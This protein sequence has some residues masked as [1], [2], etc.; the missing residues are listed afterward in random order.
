MVPLKTGHK[1]KKWPNEVKMSKILINGDDNKRLSPQGNRT[2][3]VIHMTTL[4]SVVMWTTDSVLFKARATV[5][6]TV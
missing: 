4:K 2:L 6:R 1:P 5:T 3:S